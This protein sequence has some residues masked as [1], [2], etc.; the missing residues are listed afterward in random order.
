MKVSWLE[1]CSKVDDTE[2]HQYLVHAVHADSVTDVGRCA[3][4][5]TK[6]Q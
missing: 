4:V 6:Q 3:R 2:E 1:A 5:T